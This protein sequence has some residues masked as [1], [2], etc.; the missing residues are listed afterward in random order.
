MINVNIDKKVFEIDDEKSSVLLAELESII[1]YIFL[2]LILYDK[3]DEE[4]A[5]SLLE[6]VKKNGVSR[7]KEM[8]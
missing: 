7:G 8:M 3:M 6:K 5:V 4:F 1:T 2:Q